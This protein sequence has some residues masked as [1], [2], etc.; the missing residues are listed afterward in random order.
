MESLKKKASCAPSTSNM[1]VIEVN[2]VSHDNLWVLDTSC[3]SHICTDMQ[4]LRKSKKLNKGDSDL[5]VGNWVRVVA[6]AIG[7]YA[8]TLLSGLVLHLDDFYYIPSLTKNTVSASSL[9][10]KAFHLTFSNKSCS[11]ML[12]DVFYAYYG[13][14]FTY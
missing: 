12:N 5:H 2:T 14:V 1:F 9:N 11:I 8:L 10:K 6:L 7:T 13:M 3:G 4:G